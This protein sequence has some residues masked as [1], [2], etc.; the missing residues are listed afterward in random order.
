MCVSAR[1]F[2]INVDTFRTFMMR[3]HVSCM[4][5]P[6][7]MRSCMCRSAIKFLFSHRIGIAVVGFSDAGTRKARGAVVKT[8]R[9]LNCAILRAPF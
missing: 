3:V 6:T 9:A 2:A 7:L 5:S 8:G 4:R 1:V